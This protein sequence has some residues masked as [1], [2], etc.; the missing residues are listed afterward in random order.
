[1]LFETQKKANVLLH[2]S[3]FLFLFFL[4]L[5]SRYYSLGNP[6]CHPISESSL[7]LQSVA[8]QE[9]VRGAALESER[10]DSLTSSKLS[11]L[12]ILCMQA[13]Y[14]ASVCLTFLIDEMGG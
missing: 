14:V 11:H 6:S 9:V 4:F 13:A 5:N 3:C 1:M 12:L 10:L 2:V 8:G 7:I